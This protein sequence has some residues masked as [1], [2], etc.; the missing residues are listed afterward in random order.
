MVG[1]GTSS[2]TSQYPIEKVRIPHIYTQSI[3]KFSVKTETDLNNTHKNKFI[4]HLCRSHFIMLRE[5]MKKKGDARSNFPE[6]KDNG[7]K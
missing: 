5:C 7:L 1:I 2:Y 6:L 4:Y 3:Q